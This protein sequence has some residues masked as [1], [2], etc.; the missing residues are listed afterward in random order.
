MHLW[1]RQA[2]SS[3]CS[4]HDPFALAILIPPWSKH[5]Q[6]IGLALV[7]N[8]PHGHV[9]PTLQRDD[10]GR[11]VDPKRRENF[12]RLHCSLRHMRLLQKA[13]NDW[14]GAT[15]FPGDGCLPEAPTLPLAAPVFGDGI[16]DSFFPRFSSK[17]ATFDAFYQPTSNIY[18]YTNRSNHAAVRRNRSMRCCGVPTSGKSIRWLTPAYRTSSTVCLRLRSVTKSCSDSLKGQRKSFSACNSSNG[19]VMRSAKVKA[20]QLRRSVSATCPSP[21]ITRSTQSVPSESR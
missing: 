9:K 20:E 15:Q 18:N 21:L 10:G 7:L 11:P 6:S 3:R 16:K 5:A 1:H 14:Q 19:V 8:L 2:R 4:H 17:S 12:Q 13:S